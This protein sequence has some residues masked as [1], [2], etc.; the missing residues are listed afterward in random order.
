[1]SLEGPLEG[2]DGAS[3]SEAVVQC[4]QRLGYS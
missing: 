2:G 1:M 4:A 3:L